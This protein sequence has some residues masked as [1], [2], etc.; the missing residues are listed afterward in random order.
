MKFF[1]LFLSIPAVLASQSARSGDYWDPPKTP[2]PAQPSRS[3]WAWWEGPIVHDLHLSGDQNRQIR[4]IVRDYRNRMIDARAGLEKAE[5]DLEDIFN[6]DAIDQ[7]KA[8]DAIERLA[9]ARAELTRSSSQLSVKLRAVL[10]PQQWQELQRRRPVVRW[11]PGA[12]PPAPTPR[13]GAGP[14]PVAPGATPPPPATAPP[15]PR[16]AK[17][18][19]PEI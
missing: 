9:N 1:L 2:A 10:T 12:P 11:A 16:P 15:P 14:G 3:S 5:N 4:D 17:K 18:I 13:P 6:D 19:P 7:K 8:N